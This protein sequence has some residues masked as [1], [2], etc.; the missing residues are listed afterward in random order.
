MRLSYI[1]ALGLLGLAGCS[2]NAAPPS[3]A[4]AAVVAPPTTTYVQPAP[5]IVGPAPGTTVI[6]R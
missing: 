1:V 6:T 2:V 4:P 3:V 5:S